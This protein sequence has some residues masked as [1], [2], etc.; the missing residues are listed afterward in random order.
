M[1]LQRGNVHNQLYAGFDGT[2][3][4]Q[5]D[6]LSVVL[7]TKTVARQTLAQTLLK[8]IGIQ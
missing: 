1:Y 8:R 5:L 2:F 3:Y 7:N 4:K 6:N